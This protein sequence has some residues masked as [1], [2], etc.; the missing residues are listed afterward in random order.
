MANIINYTTQIAVYK[1]VGEIQGILVD[2]GADKIMFE[3]EGKQPVAIRFFIKTNGRDVLVFLPARP[4]A[5]QKVL[6][7]MKREKGSRM[8][9]KP[10]FEQACRVAWR[11]VKDWIEAQMSMVQTEQA[12]FTEVFLPYLVDRS[13][14]TLFEVMKDS[15][16][17]L[18]EGSGE[19]SE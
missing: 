12:E 7:N 19:R 8:Q 13:G 18:P 2:N 14:R 16:Y 4:K 10:D 1:T 6:E 17:M 11:I 3:Y 9:V 5:V 15:N